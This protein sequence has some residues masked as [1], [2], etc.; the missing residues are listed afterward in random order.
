MSTHRDTLPGEIIDTGSD[1]LPRA[2][3]CRK[4]AEPGSEREVVATS[5]AEAVELYVARNFEGVVP[6]SVVFVVV[7]LSRGVFPAVAYWRVECKALAPLLLETSRTNYATAIQE[8][9]ARNV[10]R[11]RS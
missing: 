8:M 7:T 1:V 5:E 6:R 10:K 4:I 3:E 9:R 2:F 11:I